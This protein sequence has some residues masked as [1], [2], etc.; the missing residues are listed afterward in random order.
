M[1]ETNEKDAPIG[2]ITRPE[3]AGD[4]AAVRAVVRAAFP[5]AEE[6]DLV[7]A[8]RADPAWIPGL[9]WVAETP[10]GE[11]AGHALLTRCRVGGADALA[12][13]PVSV[14]PAYQK[15][16]AGAAV[17]RAALRA[18]AELGEPLAVV[19]GHPEYYPRFGFVPA[20]RMGIRASFEV[21]D[22]AL[23]ALPLNGTGAAPLPSGTI[24]YP[25]PFGV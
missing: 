4:A 8:L 3:A 25:A 24:E 6:A 22:E 16:G 20:S 9:S 17:T 18:A 2:W 5:T 1:R 10:A 11:I 12:L 7:D 13:A 14:L 23:M 21:P 15:R 19:L